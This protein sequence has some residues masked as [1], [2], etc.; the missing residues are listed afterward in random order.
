MRLPGPSL[1]LSLLAAATLAGCS[2]VPD[3]CPGPPDGWTYY[4]DPAVRA[5]APGTLPRTAE[6][7]DIP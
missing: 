2:A 6:L 3:R 7:R 1:G 5:R 4:P